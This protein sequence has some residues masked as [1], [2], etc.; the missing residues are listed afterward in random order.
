MALSEQQKK[1]LD[2]RISDLENEFREARKS[3]DTCLQL[4]AS[5]VATRSTMQAERW[6]GQT[7]VGLQY[8]TETYDMLGTALKQRESK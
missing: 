6:L 7:K 8:L 4:L 3:L 5:S 1:D 2:T